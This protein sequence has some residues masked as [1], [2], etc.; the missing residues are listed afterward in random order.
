MALVVLH[1]PPDTQ[2]EMLFRKGHPRYRVG[3]HGWLL[4]GATGMGTRYAMQNP[5]VFITQQSGLRGSGGEPLS[6]TTEAIGDH[7][8][9]SCGETRVDRN[10]SP[11][12][13]SQL[14]H[15]RNNFPLF[16]A[17]RDLVCT[18]QVAGRGGARPF[19]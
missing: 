2:L 1:F 3:G 16:I 17:E 12:T 18:S 8:M 6:D 14:R 10:P 7:G 11:K 5:T 15:D 19:S 9:K 13:R 4:R